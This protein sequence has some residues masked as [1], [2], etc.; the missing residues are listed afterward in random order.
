MRPAR[1]LPG[2]VREVAPRAGD[3]VVHARDPPALPEGAVREV[4]ADEP[5]RAEDDGSLF[6]HVWGN[7]L[8]RAHVIE[9]ELSGEVPAVLLEHE[10]D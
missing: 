4:A 2:E 8:L 7:L 6:G 3:Q 10:I 5:G 9:R 1:S